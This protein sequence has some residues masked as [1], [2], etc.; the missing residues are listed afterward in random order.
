MLDLIAFRKNGAQVPELLPGITFFNWARLMVVDA[1][2]SSKAG[3]KDLEYTGNTAVAKFEVPQ[4]VLDYVIKR[5][6]A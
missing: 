3:V 6:P 4:E 5:S 1:F 2:Y